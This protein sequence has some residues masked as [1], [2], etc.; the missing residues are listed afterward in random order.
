MSSMLVMK[1]YYEH[2]YIYIWHIVE[3]ASL[4]YPCYIHD[5]CICSSISGLHIFEE[6]L[7]EQV[8]T[9]YHYCLRIMTIFIAIYI[10]LGIVFQRQL[11]LFRVI[12]SVYMQILHQFMYETWVLQIFTSSRNIWSPTDIT[13]WHWCGS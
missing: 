13:E 12:C 8:Q 1:S 5:F 11:K 7:Y 10:P 2:I 4:L 3:S 9:F 6:N